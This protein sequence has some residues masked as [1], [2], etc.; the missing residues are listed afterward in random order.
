MRGWDVNERG[1]EG[2]SIKISN[3]CKW[4]FFGMLSE[5]DWKR[6]FIVYLLARVVCFPLRKS[7]CSLLP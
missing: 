6:E 2:I 1:T 7:Y 3:G 4:L 5:F